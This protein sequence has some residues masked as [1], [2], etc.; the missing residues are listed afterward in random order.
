MI[1]SHLSPEYKEYCKKFGIVPDN[2]AFYYSREIYKNI[3]P[4]VKTNRNWVLVNVPDCCWD[5]SI[6]FI[7]NNKNPE[8]YEWLNQYR[9]LILVC[10]N[11][12][13]LEFM[14]KLLPKCHSILIPL[15][16]DI[17]YVKQ[18]KTNEKTKDK[19]YYGR[20]EKCPKK[21]LNDKKIDKIYGKNRRANLKEVAQYKTVYS[22]GR[23]QLEAK[24]LGCKVICHK[25]EY[26]NI[27]WDLLDN[28][29][30]VSELQRLINEIDMKG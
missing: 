1:F 8:R 27:Y 18:F 28:A 11:I 3:I 23:C 19:A 4:K 2:G 6:V 7:H 16:I 21:I 12:K 9:N 13:T 30:V 20:L 25:G 15:S 10:S 5:N 26:D 17:K 22:I 24:A 14:I 29:D